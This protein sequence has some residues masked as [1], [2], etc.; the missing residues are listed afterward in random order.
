VYAR[1]DGFESDRGMKAGTPHLGCDAACL[2][3]DPTE[4]TITLRW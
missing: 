4:K 2:C 1:D 3:D